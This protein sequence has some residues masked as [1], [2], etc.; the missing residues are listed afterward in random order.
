MNNDLI[1]NTF[2]LYILINILYNKLM[3]ISKIGSSAIDKSFGRGG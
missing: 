3:D 1:K 2:T